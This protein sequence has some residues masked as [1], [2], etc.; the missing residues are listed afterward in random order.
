[1]ESTEETAPAARRSMTGRLALIALLGL[2]AFGAWRF[3][4][5]DYLNFETLRTQRQELSTFVADHR[6]LAFA[7]FILAYVVVTTLALP[8]A[9]WVT[10][11]GGYLFGLA[12]GAVATTIGA[13]LGATALFVIA[14]YLLA[15]TL[16]A[17]AG[18]F[19]KRLEAGFKDNAISY[20]LTLRLVPIVPFFIANVAPAFLGARL[21]TFVWTTAV[22][23]IP[24]VIAYTWIGAGLGA[25]FD[26]G[27]APDVSAF[28]RELAP[29]FIAL[30]LLAIAPAIYRQFRRPKPAT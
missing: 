21:S 25:A 23:I 12:G 1:M 15:D 30:A 26:A 19:L 29:A 2:V 11:L 22:G 9:F 4:V 20:L 14:R 18:P 24:G 7:T 16:R 10:I 17:R 27:E 28:A 8:G 3:G 6:M 13:T 5:F